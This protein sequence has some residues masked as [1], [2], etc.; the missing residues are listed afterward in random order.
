[1]KKKNKGITLVAL[2]ITIIILLILTG[3][4]IGRLAETELFEKTIQAKE[5]NKKVQLK[6]ELERV[7]L[8]AKI[9]KQMK[10]EYNS[11]T[12]L[13]QL[14]TSQIKDVQII[15]NVV[16]VGEYNFVIDREELIILSEE[17]V[18]KKKIGLISRIN[19]VQEDGYHMIEVIGKNEKEEIENIVYNTHVII[20]N[21]DL[22]LDGITNIEGATLINGVYEFGDERNDVATETEDAKNM[23]ILKV[24]GNLTIDENVTLTACKSENGYGGPKGMMIYCTGV[25]TNNGIIS[26]T[27]RGARAE[28]ENV[29]LYRNIDG[30]YEYIPADGALGGTEIYVPGGSGDISGNNGEDGTNRQTGGGGTGSGYSHRKAIGISVGGSGTSY[31]GGCGSGSA[32]ADGNGSWSVTSGAGSSSGGQGGNGVD[33]SSNSSSWGYVSIGGT[34]NPSGTYSTYRQGSLNYEQRNGT[35]GLLVIYSNEIVNNGTIESNG[36][37]SSTS[38]ITSSKGDVYPGGASGG[39][40]INIFYYNQFLNNGNCTANGGEAITGIWSSPTIS[41]GSGGSGSVTFTKID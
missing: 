14:I 38:N 9:D 2:V 12:Y 26:M 35:G 20:H 36:V 18:N 5:Q 17:Q 34:G 13:N 24:N 21:G 8:E 7:L 15:E 28:G 22:I 3:I 31:S 40:S 41:G 29:Y 23:V 1:M 27:A 32:T 33:G 4:T 11:D 16:I 6:D 30:T 25:I 37:S 39:G 10:E 19:E